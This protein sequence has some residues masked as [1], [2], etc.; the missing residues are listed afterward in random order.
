MILPYTLT[1]LPPMAAFFPAPGAQPTGWWMSPAAGRCRG[2][3]RQPRGAYIAGTKRVTLPGGQ[4]AALRELPSGAL[5]LPTM[6]KGWRRV[7]P[8]PNKHQ[9]RARAAA[10]MKAAQ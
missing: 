9:R 8:F 10:N 1:A 3:E 6:H 2:M 7:N 5:Y 4:P